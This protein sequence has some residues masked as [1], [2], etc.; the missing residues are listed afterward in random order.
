[1]KHSRWVDG[2]FCRLFKKHRYYTKF[3]KVLY[4][5]LVFIY[6]KFPFKIIFF[7]RYY[8]L[9]C[10]MSLDTF[11][12]REIGK[13]KFLDGKLRS[14][15][16]HQSTQIQFQ[17]TILLTQINNV[18]AGAFVVMSIVHYLLWSDSIEKFIIISF[19]QFKREKNFVVQLI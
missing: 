2:Q 7:F 11:P 14:S 15:S 12:T 13:K 1:M 4:D 10:H 18:L 8:K 6:F 19:K 16:V 17:V 3:T 9:I 5:N